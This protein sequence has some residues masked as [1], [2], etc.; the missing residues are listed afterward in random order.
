MSSIMLVAAKFKLL[1]FCAGHKAEH[2]VNIK[3]RHKPRAAKSLK[4]PRHR[5]KH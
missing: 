4:M 1:K 5:L 2:K 3:N